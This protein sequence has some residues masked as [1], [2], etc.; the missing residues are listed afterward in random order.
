MRFS[1]VNLP[2]ATRALDTDRQQPSESSYTTSGPICQTDLRRTRK[3]G[4]E[5]KDMKSPMFKEAFGIDP[6]SQAIQRVGQ[7][8]K[9][10]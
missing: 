8:V 10:T 9:L 4:Q 2:P 7:D 6:P 5:K 1:Y 3:E